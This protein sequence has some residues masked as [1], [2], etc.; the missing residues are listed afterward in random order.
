MKK[1]LAILLTTS[2]FMSS[3]SKE[4]DSLNPQSD[5][6]I[7]LFE[8]ADGKYDA[9]GHG[10][11]V[12]IDYATLNATRFPVI[13]IEKLAVDYPEYVRVI[14]ND[15]I[16]AKYNIYSSEN[17]FEYSKEMSASQTKQQVLLF[18]KRILVP[19][20]QIQTLQV[21]NLTENIFMLH[22]IIM[23]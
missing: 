19:H 2:L 11:D 17:A 4:I 15:D 1:T 20:F 10:T 14:L 7:G 9:A 12:T 5:T 23:Q 16:Q 13:N 6:E 22:T 18:L 8:F 21:K 3:C